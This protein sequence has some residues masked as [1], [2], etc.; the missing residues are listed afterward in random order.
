MLSIN[1]AQE[2]NQLDTVCR[3]TRQSEGWGGGVGGG[4]RAYDSEQKMENETVKQL[5]CWP[6]P[7]MT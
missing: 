1:Y 6:A 3:D 2:M 7:W 4:R 5:I